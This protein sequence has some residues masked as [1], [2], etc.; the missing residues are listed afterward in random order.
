[1]LIRQTTVLLRF[2]SPKVLLAAA[3][4]LG[5]MS[6]QPTVG[7][8]AVLGL[9]IG[10]LGMLLCYALQLRLI[11]LIVVFLALVSDNVAERPG[12]G[13][14]ETPLYLPGKFL[15]ASLGSS[16]GIPGLKLFGIEALLALL[17]VHASLLRDPGTAIASESVRVYARAARAALTVIALWTVYG[18]LRGGSLSF[19]ILQVRAIVMSVSLPLLWCRCFPRESDTRE[20]LAVMVS[21]ATTRALVCLFTRPKLFSAPGLAGDNLGGGFYV[22]TH[23]DSVLWVSAATIC[24]LGVLHA[25]RR[26]QVLLYLCLATI[27]LGAI[28][29]NNRRIA[30]VGLGSSVL[31][32]YFAGPPRIRHISHRL[33][34]FTLPVALV[35]L[36]AGWN[37]E[38]TW[39][40]PARAIQSVI[41]QQDSSS[42]TRDVENYN[43]T[44]TM[45]AHPIVGSGFGH[46]Y[47]ERVRM[48]DIS[49]IFSGYRYVPHNS[50]L[51]LFGFCG[52][53]G[54]ALLWLPFVVAVFIARSASQGSP[55]T[56]GLVACLATIAAVASHGVQ[57]FGDMGAHSWLGALTLSLL[58]A[59]ALIQHGAMHGSDIDRGMTA[60]IN[61]R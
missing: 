55:T 35:Y 1:M 50:I 37:R 61:D 6:V 43:L 51:G 54:F 40:L 20:V 3:A 18:L 28:A 15:Y 46:E 8:V 60:R 14:V 31:A 16:L 48:H 2:R 52:P 29:A 26:S 44:V 25:Q 9:V 19:A 4:L 36:A 38:A 45:K 58:I 34:R 56:D 59:L 27:L 53:L 47:I 49:S 11:A 39:A 21:A 57:A 13:L 7:G 41:E 10:G 42:Q 5:A 17:L 30:F 23:S 12:M 33:L 32:I 24:I 22:M